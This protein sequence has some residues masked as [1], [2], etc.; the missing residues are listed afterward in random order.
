SF[1][2]QGGNT[3]ALDGLSLRIRTGTTVAFVGPSGSGKSTAVDMILGF[4]QPESG[5]IHLD[6]QPL[7]DVSDAWRKRLGYVPQDVSI[8]DGS[9]A[10]NVA[11]SW[12]DDYDEARV[13]S[14]L[15]QASL[16]ETIDSRPDGIHG[17]V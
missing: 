5:S 16:L 15:Q 17:R 3:R 11:L 9:V 2:Y 10:A 8:F 4:I 13:R 7:A 1:T 14:A 12:T 6:G